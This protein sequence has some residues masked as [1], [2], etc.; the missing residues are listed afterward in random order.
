[1][2]PT[3]PR[4]QSCASLN[5]ARLRTWTKAIV[6][7]VAP[8]PTD[9]ARAFGL[10]EYLIGLCLNFFVQAWA[11][12]LATELWHFGDFITRRRKYKIWFQNYEGEAQG[13]CAG[14]SVD[15]GLL[16]NVVSDTRATCG[17]DDLRHSPRYEARV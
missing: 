6:N 13:L 2:L 10:V 12:K 1:M 11:A 7:H 4:G 5:H 15:W 3:T 8:L 9:C 16:T 17:T 14:V